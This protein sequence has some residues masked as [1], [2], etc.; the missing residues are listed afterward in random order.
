MLSVKMGLLYLLDKE[1]YFIKL[2]VH[3]HKKFVTLIFHQQSIYKEKKLICHLPS[4]IDLQSKKINMPSS[5]EKQV[6][7]SLPIIYDSCDDND[8]NNED[9]SDNQE[10][11]NENDDMK[12]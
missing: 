8:G 5:I 10:S 2:I 4:T 7:K 1:V 11:H 9:S 3:E 12:K 6:N